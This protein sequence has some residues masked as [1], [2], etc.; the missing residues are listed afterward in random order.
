VCA[1]GASNEADFSTGA[2][3]LDFWYLNTILL[4][5]DVAT[6]A[7]RSALIWLGELLRTAVE[8]INGRAV[9]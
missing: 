7:G 1:G 9:C 3:F 4:H 8:S 2:V 5:E 6:N